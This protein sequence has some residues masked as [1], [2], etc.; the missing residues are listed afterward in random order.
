MH[1]HGF[2]SLLTLGLVWLLLGGPAAAGTEARPEE[3]T[4]EA[5]S[6]ALRPIAEDV[7]RC[8]KEP[9]AKLAELAEILEEAQATGDFSRLM[10]LQGEMVAL[11]DTSTDCFDELEKKYPKIAEDEEKI[12][13]VNSIVDDLCPRPELGFDS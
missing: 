10:T 9:H 13:S 12:D 5:R 3:A 8:L 4:E 11:T 6:K 2:G 1:R 7:C